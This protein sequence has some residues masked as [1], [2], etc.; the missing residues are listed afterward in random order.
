MTHTG[1]DKNIFFR[2][3]S[4]LGKRYA[5][6]FFLKKDSIFILAT[7]FKH[8]EEIL[9]ENA[10]KTGKYGLY[11]LVH[12]LTST[13]PWKLIPMEITWTPEQPWA[14]YVERERVRC[15][16]KTY[17]RPQTAISTALLPLLQSTVLLFWAASC[18]RQCCVLLFSVS[19][20]SLVTALCS[21]VFGIIVFSCLHRCV[22]PSLHECRRR[23]VNLEAA[24]TQLPGCTKSCCSFLKV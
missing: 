21:L 19:L 15:G 24:P 9:L 23:G 12:L 18:L 10:L 17:A 7:Y 16:A 22:C 13:R 3:F 5:S 8:R 20:C 4:N 11:A 14:R 1:P 6:R 2:N